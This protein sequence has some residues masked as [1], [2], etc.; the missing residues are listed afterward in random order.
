[1][2]SNCYNIHLYPTVILVNALPVNLDCLMQGDSELKTLAPGEKINLPI[3]EIGYSCLTLQ[4]IMYNLVRLVSIICHTFL[5]DAQKSG[6]LVF[7]L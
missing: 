3:V 7:I 4:V 5:V 2:S 1:M 6:M